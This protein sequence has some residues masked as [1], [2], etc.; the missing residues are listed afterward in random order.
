MLYLIV[1]L[2]LL[3]TPILTAGL[4]TNLHPSF[5]DVQRC[6]T[7][8][9]DR[10]CYSSKRPGNQRVDGLVGIITCVETGQRKEKLPCSLT[11]SW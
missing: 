9:T 5:D 4:S 7:K 8:H 2:V 3:R 11:G 1:Q 6:V 10:S